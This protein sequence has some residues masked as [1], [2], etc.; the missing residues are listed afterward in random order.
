MPLTALPSAAPPVM[1][2][3]LRTVPLPVALV[4]RPFPP[5]TS[6]VP[7]PEMWVPA[8]AVQRVVD[9]TE[10]AA[11]RCGDSDR[12]LDERAASV[13]VGLAEPGLADDRRRADGDSRTAAAELQQRRCLREVEAEGAGERHVQRRGRRGVGPGRRGGEWHRHGAERAHQQ[14]VVLEWTLD[15][16][17]PES[18]IAD[19]ER[20]S[21]AVV[22]VVGWPSVPLGGRCAPVPALRSMAARVTRHR[23]AAQDERNTSGR[24]GPVRVA[25]WLLLTTVRARLLCCGASRL[26]DRARRP[27]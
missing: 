14:C 18:R 10:P 20:T 7:L 25:G 13:V 1:T 16:A 12:V 6:K 17:A 22:P 19:D 11:V 27:N 21:R 9:R 4:K 3:K 2:A 15:M 26:D 24:H 23:T 5:T 8:D